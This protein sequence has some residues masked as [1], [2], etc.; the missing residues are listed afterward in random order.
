MIGS[1]NLPRN[2]NTFEVN[3]QMQVEPIASPGNIPLPSHDILTDQHSGSVLSIPPSYD[4]STDQ[5]PDPML[6]AQQPHNVQ[7]IVLPSHST[8]AKTILDGQIIP[9]T[10][11]R[12]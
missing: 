7:S 2:S 11:K 1:P 5:Q 12:V 4:I 3:T 6:C 8:P 10:F 9:S